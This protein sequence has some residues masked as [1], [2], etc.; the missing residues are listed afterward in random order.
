[1]HSHGA[2]F[3][4][5]DK[6]TMLNHRAKNVAFYLKNAADNKINAGVKRKFQ[7]A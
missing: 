3:S 6:I 2:F 4:E 1:V 7:A 5:R